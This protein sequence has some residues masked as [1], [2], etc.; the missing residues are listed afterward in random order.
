[1]KPYIQRRADAAPVTQGIVC[2]LFSAPAY[3]VYA[4]RQRSWWMFFGPFLIL[5]A[6][7]GGMSDKD[8]YD[9]E[10]RLAKYAIQAVAGATCGLLAAQNKKEAQKKLEHDSHIKPQAVV[11]TEEVAK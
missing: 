9:S 5:L 7:L 4:I 6:L 11:V 1:M 10:N 2:F 3:L 8:F